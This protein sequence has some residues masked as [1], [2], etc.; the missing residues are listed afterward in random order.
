[1][2][3]SRRDLL[4]APEAVE[5]V[6]AV[7]A[8][9]EKRPV[10]RGCVRRTECCQFR[11]TGKTP[12]LT[13]GEAMVA[14]EALRRTGVHRLAAKKNGNC[15]VLDESTGQCQIYADRPFGCRTHF[16]A[17]AGGL[18]PRR[19]IQDLIWQLEDLD[20]RL[21]GVGPQRLPVALEEGL[22]RSHAQGTAR[23]AEVRAVQVKD[24]PRSR[25]R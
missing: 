8:E 17:A 1:M 5:A 3:N 9:L 21:G 2:R 6:K 25:G 22:A 12:Y 16:C 24:A 11:F 13:R 18:R 10:E 4:S 20:A 14:V 23:G 7:Y 15:P 19:E